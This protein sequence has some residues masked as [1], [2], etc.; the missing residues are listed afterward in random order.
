MG[1]ATMVLPDFS[2][3]FD[4]GFY[5]GEEAGIHSGTRA[6]GWILSRVF[7]G[8]QALFNGTIGDQPYAQFLAPCKGPI[9]FNSSMKQTIVDLI[10]SQRNAMSRQGRIGCQHA[11]LSKVGNADGASQPTLHTFGKP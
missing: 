8:E 6:R 4:Q 10:R 3:Q 7:A 5:F 11:R 2:D 1:L 9:F